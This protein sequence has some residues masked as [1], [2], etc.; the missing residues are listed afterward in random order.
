MPE[1]CFHIIERFPSMISRPAIKR[2]YRNRKTPETIIRRGVKGERA[3]YQIDPN[4]SLGVVA[5]YDCEKCECARWPEGHNAGNIPEPASKPMLECESCGNNR[6]ELTELVDPE[7]ETPQ[8]LCNT[9]FN[10]E[11]GRYLRRHQ[12]TRNR[13]VHADNPAFALLV[14]GTDVAG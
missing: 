4:R 9:C 14:V 7:D 12:W 3:D 5:C 13:R 11:A 1:R 2:C 8:L 6:R 10:R